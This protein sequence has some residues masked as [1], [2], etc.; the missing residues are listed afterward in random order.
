MN[1]SASVFEPTS[2]FQVYT[3]GDYRNVLGRLLEKSGS[4]DR[5]LL[6]SMSMEPSEPAIGELL[7]QAHAAARRGATVHLGVDAFTFLMGKG[8][9]P[10]WYHPTFPEKMHPYYQ[11]KYDLL[12]SFNDTPD[13]HSYIINKPSRRFS[14]PV[15]GRS[16]LKIAI[17]NDYVFIG[18]CNFEG[19]DW[20]DMMVGRQDIQAADWLYDTIVPALQQGTIRT[21]LDSTDREL[22]LNDST[23][24]LLDAGVPNQSIIL[25][26]ALTLIDSAEQWLT[27]TCQYFPNSVT[28]QHLLHAHKRGVK[29]EIIFAHPSRQGLIGGA[30]QQVS[31]MIE[32]SRLPRHMF[33][34]ALKRT[35]PMLHAKLI[36][37]DK[38]VM[39]GSHNYVRA[40][41]K[42]GTAEIALH[43]T[44][45]NLTRKAL[46]VLR[47]Q[48]P[49]H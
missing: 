35:D 20:I 40:G 12:K 37:C 31:L 32:K 41:V 39:I 48:L 5:I 44:N 29:V 46:A 15:A 23:K 49:G 10:L 45:S 18:G 34:Q 43:S 6:T 38:G 14:L 22:Q 8:L 30:G 19:A 21:A 24:L 7:E 17:V 16:H 11:R 28:A 27:I 36:A 25:K 2:N 1:N 33:K 26:Q 42:L 13:G 9:G 47:R 3:P 4:G